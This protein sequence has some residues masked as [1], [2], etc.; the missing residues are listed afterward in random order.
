MPSGVSGRRVLRFGDYEADLRT[1]RLSKRGIRIKL[2]D[3][4]FQVLATLLERAGEVVTREEFQSRLWPDRVSLDFENNLNTV[5][6]RLREAISD[7]AEHPRFIDTLPKRGYR[8]LA[9]VF[10][11]EAHPEAPRAAR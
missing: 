2:P 10:G 7:S 3:Q 9:P 11:A 8:F 6:A 4:S 1:G 5:V